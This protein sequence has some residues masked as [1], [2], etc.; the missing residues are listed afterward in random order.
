[1]AKVASGNRSLLQ[2][3]FKR[4]NS[5]AQKCKVLPMIPIKYLIS[6]LLVLILKSSRIGKTSC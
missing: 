2:K 3:L 6:F 4:Q 5:T 1:M